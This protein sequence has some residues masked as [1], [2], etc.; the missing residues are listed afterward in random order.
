M[1]VELCT[2]QLF[3]L[4]L[5]CYFGRYHFGHFLLKSTI[6][7]VLGI[8]TRGILFC[9]PLLEIYSGHLFIGALEWWGGVVNNFLQAP[10]GGGVKSPVDSYSTNSFRVVV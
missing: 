8:L 10:L 9:V 7:S 4:V 3:L 2:K 5:G 6:C 1:C